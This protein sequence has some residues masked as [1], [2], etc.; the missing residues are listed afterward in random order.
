MC[1][2]LSA[3]VSNKQADLVYKMTNE[4]EMQLTFLPPTKKVYAKAPLYFI[5]PGGG[6]H[7]ESRKSMIDFSRPSVDVLRENGYAVVSIDYRTISMQGIAMT[8]IVTDCFDALR[9]VCFYADVLEIDKYNI[10]TSGHSAGGH[11]ALMVAYGN[12]EDFVCE[13][14]INAD[15]KITATVPLSPITVLYD[16]GEYPKT[17][18]LG[19]LE[20]RFVGCD[21]IET[22]KLTSPITYVKRDS[23]PTLFCAGDSDD[24]VL[25][26]SSQIMCEELK[27]A[28]TDAEIAISRN[29]GHCFE[30]KGDGEDPS[31]NR[32]EIQDMLIDFVLKHTKP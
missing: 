9:Y 20:D 25:C 23:P 15:Y 21:N 6:W 27:K 10:I 11:L 1:N 14:S 18:N 19:T 28:G 32:D 7:S 13:T 30:K 26:N 16:N 31:P 24:L 4:K 29:G 22:R 8:D 2:L 17:H 5:I 3:P 12:G